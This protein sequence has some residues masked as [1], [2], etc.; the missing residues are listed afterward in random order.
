MRSNGEIGDNAF[1]RGEA[2]LDV[3]EMSAVGVQYP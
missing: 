2:Q 1:H 3:A